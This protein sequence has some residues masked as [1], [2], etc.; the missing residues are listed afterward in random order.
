[1][2]EN[3]LRV[4]MVLFLCDSLSDLISEHR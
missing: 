4:H 1:M 2:M 3:H